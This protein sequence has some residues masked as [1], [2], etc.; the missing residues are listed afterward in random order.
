MEKDP[1][2]ALDDCWSETENGK[3]KG[4]EPSNYPLSGLL[5]FLVVA[6]CPFVHLVGVYRTTLLKEF[7]GAETATKLSLRDTYLNLRSVM[8][9]NFS[10]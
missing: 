3:R 5:P 4:R 10:P 6:L 9:A 7:E 8:R 1:L 2:C